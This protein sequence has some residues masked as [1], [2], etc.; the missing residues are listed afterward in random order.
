MSDSYTTT[1]IQQLLNILIIFKVHLL[2][3]NYLYTYSTMILCYKQLIN[4][5]ISIF[6][7]NIDIT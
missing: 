7:C 6:R 2:N 4:I 5:A 3:L 1:F